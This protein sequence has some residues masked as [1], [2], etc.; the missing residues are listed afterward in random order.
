M[1]WHLILSS[2]ICRVIKFSRNIQIHQPISMLLQQF[3]TRIYS[4]DSNSLCLHIPEEL[5]GNKVLMGNTNKNIPNLQNNHPVIFVVIHVFSM[6]FTKYLKANL[7][8][9][10]CLQICHKTRLLLIHALKANYQESET[11]KLTPTILIWW[12]FLFKVLL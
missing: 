8:P 10:C 4:F 12:I 6:Y 1:L 9:Y 2:C 5:P 3:W 7:F 11:N